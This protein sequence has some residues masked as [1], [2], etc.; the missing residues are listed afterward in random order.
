MF[1]ASADLYDLIY[2]SLK[3]YPAE[4]ARIAALLARVHP[5]ARALLDVGCGTGEHARLLARDHGFAVD[6]I[7]LDPAF[8]R[9][10]AAKHPAGTFTVAD[11]TGFDLGRRYDAVL[12]LFSAI[13]YV[14]TLENVGRALAC[15]RR[16][17]AP[18]GVVVVEPWLTPDVLTP[19]RVSVHTAEA[20]GVTVCRMS[21]LAVEGR[22]SRIRFAYL[23]GRPDGITHARELHEL[24]LFTV[25]ETRGCFEAAGFAV[26]HDPEGLSGRGLSVAR[27]PDGRA[28]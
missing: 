1:S 6:G 15:F 18:G 4:A 12:C 17:L 2:T 26:D 23:V 7:D 20:A 22:L 3:D 13:G 28:G 16:H 9:L 11:M 25:A 27:R 19:G 5:S 14:R 21:H 8:V 10:A 24:G